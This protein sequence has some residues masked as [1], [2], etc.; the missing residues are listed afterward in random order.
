[1]LKLIA[2]S[3]RFKLK[4]RLNFSLFIFFFIFAAKCRSLCI[5]SLLVFP[6]YGIVG[7]EN[8]VK[9]VY[10]EHKF[11]SYNFLKLLRVK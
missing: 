3:K 11:Q 10:G 4:S 1:M 8:H 9:G 5:I 2:I 6:S 7:I